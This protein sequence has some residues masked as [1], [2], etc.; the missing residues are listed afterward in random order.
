MDVEE[1]ELFELFANWVIF[2]AF[3]RLLIVFKINFLGKVFQEYHRSVKQFEYVCKGYLHSKRA[4][5]K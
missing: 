1:I 3:C 4:E 2:H 5:I